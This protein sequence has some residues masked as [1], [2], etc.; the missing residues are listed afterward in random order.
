LTRADAYTVYRRDENGMWTRITGDLDHQQIQDWHAH[1]Q[2][3]T[4]HMAGSLAR[5]LDQAVTIM[6]QPEPEPDADSAQD[7]SEPAEVKANDVQSGRPCPFCD[8]SLDGHGTQC[9]IRAW[10][11]PRDDLPIWADAPNTSGTM[12]AAPKPRRVS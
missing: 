2:T 11:D 6:E 5:W 4:G 10:D 7:D 9:G 3:P 8:A 1:R 12:P